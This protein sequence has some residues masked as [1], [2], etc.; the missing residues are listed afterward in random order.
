MAPILLRCGSELAQREAAG[1]D[2]RVLLVYELAHASSGAWQCLKHGCA[3][4][5]FGFVALAQRTR[6]QSR[7]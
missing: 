6:L 7:L 2:L 4:G 1:D 3:L 5:P